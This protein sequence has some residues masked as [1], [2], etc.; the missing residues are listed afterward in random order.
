MIESAKLLLL[1]RV[2]G[3]GGGGMSAAVVSL[4]DFICPARPYFQPASAVL[5]LESPVHR[6][7]W[8]KLCKHVFLLEIAAAGYTI[9][10]MLHGPGTRQSVST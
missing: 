6:C 1:A 5:A 3:A 2:Q 4:P 8:C 7:G 9:R 10:L